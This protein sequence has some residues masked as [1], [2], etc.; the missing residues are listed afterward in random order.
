VPECR[1]LHR[2]SLY[3]AAW[4]IRAARLLCDLENVVFFCDALGEFP[5]AQILTLRASPKGVSLVE[6]QF[7]VTAVIRIQTQHINIFRGFHTFLLRVIDGVIERFRSLLCSRSAA[8]LCRQQANETSRD[9][10]VFCYHCG[11]I[12]A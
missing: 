1:F 2:H 4:K 6:D 9:R 8:L 3:E 5:T 11:R 12:R 7:L 10:T